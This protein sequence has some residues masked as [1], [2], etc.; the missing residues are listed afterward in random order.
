MS[1]C[2]TLD[3]YHA[4]QYVHDLVNQMPKR[5]GAKEQKRLLDEFIGQLKSGEIQKI[6]D[7]IASIFI[8]K[9][10]LVKRWL[11]YLDK[12]QNRMKYADYQSDGFMRGSGI[13]ESAIRRIINL[14]FKNASTFWLEENVEKL[15]F[16]RAALVAGR[17]D[18]LMNNI[19]KQT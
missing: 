11:N 1:S 3:Y 12:H 19:V 17:W 14:R 2:V 7:K 10:D 18:I 13:I 8:R 9:T 6:L 4:S 15:Y 5:I 16:L